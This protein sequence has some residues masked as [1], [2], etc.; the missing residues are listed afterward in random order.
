MIKPFD[1]CLIGEDMN[2]WNEQSRILGVYM[3]LMYDYGYELE[4]ATINENLC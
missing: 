1:E 3:K 4:G 2:Y